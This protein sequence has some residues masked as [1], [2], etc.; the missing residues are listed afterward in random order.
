MRDQIAMQDAKRRYSEALA[1]YTLEQWRTLASDLG[2]G[3]GSPNSAVGSLHSSSALDS[4]SGSASDEPG[5]QRKSSDPDVEREIA[6]GMQNVTL[7][8]RQGVSLSA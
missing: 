8:P 4:D 5:R 1:A 3:P 6:I 7:S 2:L